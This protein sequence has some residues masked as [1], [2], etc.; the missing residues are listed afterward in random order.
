MFDTTG[1]QIID[2]YARVFEEPAQENFLPAI[3]GM[4]MAAGTVA[5]IA[6]QDALAL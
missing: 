4:A 1:F 3:R 6:E 2:I 5:N